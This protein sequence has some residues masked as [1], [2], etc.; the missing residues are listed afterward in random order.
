[1]PNKEA[2][3][4]DSKTFQESMNKLTQHLNTNYYSLYRE[5]H[6]KDI[7]PRVF[8]EEILGIDIQDFRFHC[9]SGKVGFIQVANATHTHNDLFDTQWN[10]L[11]LSYLNPPS[12]NPPPPPIELDS[13][14][15]IAQ[16]LSCAIN[17][18]RVDLYCTNQ[19]VF[20]GELTFTPN[21]GIGKFNPHIH[22]KTFGDLWENE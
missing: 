12:E 4:A 16:K 11:E 6:Y 13:M 18:V 1:M 14:C 15:V 21:G 8:V 9:F 7:E 2:F 17:Y 10:R 3:L 20:V 19:K 5:W 22:D